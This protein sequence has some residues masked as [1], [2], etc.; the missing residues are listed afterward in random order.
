MKTGQTLRLRWGAATHDT[1]RD[2]PLPAGWTA[3]VYPPRDRAAL[4]DEEV[5][6]AFAQ[7]VGVAPIRQAARGARTAV[8][9]VDDFRRPTPAERLCRLVI[10]ELGL[11]GLHRIEPS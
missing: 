5:A 2:F 6:R 4:T 8:L 9:L 11:A 7:P 10:A 1:E 3:T